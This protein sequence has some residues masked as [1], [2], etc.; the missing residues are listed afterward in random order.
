MRIALDADGGCRGVCTEQLGP[1]EIVA[2]DENGA[3]LARIS[4]DGQPPTRPEPAPR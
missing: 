3:V 4:D 2:F 1:F